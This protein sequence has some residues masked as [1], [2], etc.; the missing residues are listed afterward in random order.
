MEGR[1][2]RSIS[3]ARGSLLLTAA[4]SF[5]AVLPL[6]AQEAKTEAGKSGKPLSL[7]ADVAVPTP[8]FT[9][10]PFA[11]PTYTK[12]WDPWQTLSPTPTSTPTTPSQDTATFTLTATPT[13]TG[14]Q[15]TQTFTPTSTQ[16]ISRAG[17]VLLSTAYSNAYDRWDGF[18]WD[19]N[20]SSYIGS[21]V[22]RDFTKPDLDTLEPT[23][24]AMLTSDVKYAWLDED[25]DLPGI[26]N[27]LMVSV[28]AQVGQVNSSSGSG[29]QSFQAGNFMASVYGV[30]SKSIERDLSVH[31][32]F[33]YGLKDAF[34]DLAPDVVNMNHAR[35]LYL[36]TPKLKTLVEDPACVF[37]SGMSARFLD[38]NWKF[39]V[40]K[41][42]PAL[43][44]PILFNTRIEGLPMA[45]NLGYE[46][47]DGGFAVLG[48]VS[49]RFTLLPQVP[50]Y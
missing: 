36:A 13:A 20:F 45:F 22:S 24:L 47:W 23:G 40:W 46:G 37:Y 5:F 50:A 21:I 35:L 48:Y 2:S 44:N 38:R 34:Q 28:L 8:T 27:G 18:N 30:M 15:P 10:D 42:F 1:R 9:R 4:L 31:A 6:V 25:G 43:R 16:V 11:T 29:N 14:T 12:T 3:C 39:E 33:L 26:A 41:P 17:L 32:G 19:V 49:F 7:S